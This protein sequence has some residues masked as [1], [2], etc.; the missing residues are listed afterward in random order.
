MPIPNRSS[1]AGP[2]QDERLTPQWF[3][4]NAPSYEADDEM[5]DE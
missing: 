4:D 1:D 5:E 2:T 3:E